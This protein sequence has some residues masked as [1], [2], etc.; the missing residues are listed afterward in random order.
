[1]RRVWINALPPV[2]FAFLTIGGGAALREELAYDADPAGKADYYADRVIGV[3]IGAN[4]GGLQALLFLWLAVLVAQ[5]LRASSDRGM[6]AFVPA[7]GAAVCAVL[8]VGA[9]TQIAAIADQPPYDPGA[10]EAFF[11]LRQGMLNMYAL[12]LGA[13]LLVVGLV[14]V[15]TRGLLPRWVGWSALVIA[16]PMVLLP[17]RTLPVLATM[18][19]CLAVAGPL[20]RPLELPQQAVNARVTTP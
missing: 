13:F 5:R 11:Q 12:G 8:L 2:G 9:A 14:V 15:R 6:V 19:W 7:I 1:M 18:L 17:D 4:L 10:S 3:G 20:T 16:V